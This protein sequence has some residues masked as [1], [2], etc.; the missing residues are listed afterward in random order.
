MEDAC[1]E[2]SFHFHCKP[3]TLIKLIK[4]PLY[5]F[6]PGNATTQ[7]NFLKLSEM[8]GI[9]IYQNASEW[10]LLQG[11]ATLAPNESELIYFFFNVFQKRKIVLSN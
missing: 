6:F 2:G 10:L 9:L 1:E 11:F 4:I 5:V 8:T 3:T 7:S